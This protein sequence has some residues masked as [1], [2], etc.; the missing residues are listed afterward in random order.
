MDGITPERGI[1][2]A[3]GVNAPMPTPSRVFPT[4]CKCGH[5]KTVHNGKNNVLYPDGHCTATLTWDG[6]KRNR[7]G[8]HWITEHCFCEKFK[9]KKRGTT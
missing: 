8:P 7:V 4:P 3:R 6:P 2:E 1:W 5:L 9:A